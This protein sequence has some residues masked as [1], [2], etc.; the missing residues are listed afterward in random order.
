MIVAVE[1]AE[2][3]TS[4]RPGR[5]RDARADQVILDAAAAVLAECG[6]QGFSVDA[7]AA[8]AGVGKATIY[9][10]WPS[11]AE[12]LL[13]IAHLGTPDVTVPDTGSV[14]EDLV[15]LTSAMMR[16]MRDT[17]AGRILPAVMAEAA[18]N[19]EMRAT[20]ERFVTE[21]RGRAVGA[22]Q[23]GIERGELPAGTDAD[24][25]VDLVSSPIMLRIWLTQLPVD[26]ELVKHAVDAVLDGIR[27]PR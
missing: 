6:V 1:S 21:R 13:E 23:R 8:R 17:P 27:D 14:R 19:P 15:R 20:L 2:A 18:V 26:D 3:T 4:R 12:L 9:R 5:P 10:R 16:K 22:V 24:L 7:V 25:V 11:R